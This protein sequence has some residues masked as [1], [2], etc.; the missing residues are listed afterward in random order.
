MMPHTGA[1][2]KDI[3]QRPAEL[4]APRYGTLFRPGLRPAIFF[5]FVLLAWVWNQ[6]IQLHTFLYIQARLQREG[7]CGMSVLKEKKWQR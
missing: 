4:I 6:L 7:K 1:T 2:N 3:T 5:F